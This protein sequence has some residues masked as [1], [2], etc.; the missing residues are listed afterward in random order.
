MVVV[1]VLI[2]WV[3]SNFLLMKNERF[4]LYYGMDCLSSENLIS[5]SQRIQLSHEPASISF[6]SSVLYM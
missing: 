4:L 5:A 1:H 3:R 2:L 6:Q